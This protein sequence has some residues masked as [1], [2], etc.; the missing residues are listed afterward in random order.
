MTD[1]PMEFT[2]FFRREFVA[3]LRAVELI[4]RDH[5]RA[6]LTAGVPALIM[7]GAFNPYSA[8]LP[9]VQTATAGAPNVF[10]LEIPNQSYN[11]LGYTEC[12]RAIRN[13]WVDNPTAAP[14][15]N[16]CLDTISA[17]PLAP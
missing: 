8:S 3:V 10:A 14:A 1:A 5:G 2:A 11:V 12:P 13:A 6:E 15:D 4:L 16:S 9:D 7:R 17:P